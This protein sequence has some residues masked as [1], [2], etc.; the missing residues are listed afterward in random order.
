MTNLRVRTRLVT[1]GA[2]FWYHVVYTY[3]NSFF[4]VDFNFRCVDVVDEIDVWKKKHDKVRFTILFRL[5][6]EEY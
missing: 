6:S 5:D 2:C 3:P 4:I 1:R